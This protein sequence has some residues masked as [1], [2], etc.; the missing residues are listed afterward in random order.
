MGQEG[1]DVGKV[2][3]ACPSGRALAAAGVAALAVVL[4]T[5]P[6]L[7]A[8]GLVPADAVF[9]GVAASLVAVTGGGKLAAVAW[10]LGALLLAS[11]GP[12]TAGARI[13]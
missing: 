8:A 12:R 6:V 2:V 1:V 4:L 10:G 9:T 5:L 13:D 11:P 3:V 7:V